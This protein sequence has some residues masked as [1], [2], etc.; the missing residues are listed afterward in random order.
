MRR[1]HQHRNSGHIPPTPLCN[2][3]ERDSLNSKR[4]VSCPRFHFYSFRMCWY[5]RKFHMFSDRGCWRFRRSTKKRDEK[6]V[7]LCIRNIMYKCGS[8]GITLHGADFMWNSGCKIGDKERI[9]L[10]IWQSFVSSIFW[11]R[12]FI[13]EMFSYHNIDYSFI[14]KLET[15]TISEIRDL[16]KLLLS[17]LNSKSYKFMIKNNLSEDSLRGLTVGV[18]KY[19]FFSTYNRSSHSLIQIS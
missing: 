3:N 8:H 17:F 5:W 19:P 4:F 12:L 6:Y 15:T 1:I 14:E 11:E 13:M 10:E 9:F 18:I 7:S 2:N 16:M